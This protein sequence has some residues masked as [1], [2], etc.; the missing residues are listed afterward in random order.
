MQT[1]PPS[2]CSHCY[3]RCAQ[4]WIEWKI[5]FPIFIFRVMAVC[6]YNLQVTHRDFQVCH[7][8][9]KKI[10]Q[11]WSNLQKGCA[12]SWNEWKIN[13]TI[14]IFLVIVDFV[15]NFQVFLPTKNVYINTDFCAICSF[16][17]MVYFVFDIYSELIW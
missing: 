5:N 2:F 14:F 6:K 12:M 11:K 7:Q 9:K 10:V 13:F 1:L 3:D 4:C 17:D 15:H 16:W 8:P